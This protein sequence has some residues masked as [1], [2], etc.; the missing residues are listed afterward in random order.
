MSDDDR[1]LRR[2][3][4]LAE[5]SARTGGGPFGALVVDR[6][7]VLAEA[8]N[9]VT[10]KG[11]P[12]AHAEVEAIRAAALARGSHA[13]TGCTLYSS[14]EPCPMC[15]GAIHWARI[16]RVVFAADRH[17]AA[18]AGFDDQRLYEELARAPKTRAVA[19]QRQLAAEGRAPFEA[20]RLNQDR[21]EY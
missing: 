3:I 16:E 2:A 12:T 1:F 4:Q 15:F 19:F 10:R 20:W 18:A 7:G 13:L 9:G 11:D 21:R 8:A 14:C 17:D 5:Q 6:S